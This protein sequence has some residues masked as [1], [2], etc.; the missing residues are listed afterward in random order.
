MNSVGSLVCSLQ[1]KFAPHWEA[2]E[3]KFYL[4]YRDAVHVSWCAEAQKNEPDVDAHCWTQ[5]YAG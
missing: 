4:D 1:E 3:S 2:A 5:F